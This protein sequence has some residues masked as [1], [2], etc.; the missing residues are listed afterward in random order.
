M[1][2]E[3]KYF[4]YLMIGNVYLKRD[5]EYNWGKVVLWRDMYIGII[6]SQA[7]LLELMW[8]FNQGKFRCI[9]IIN[10]NH[11]KVS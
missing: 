1:T 2:I 11:Q 8:T 3:Y 10:S 9:E 5:I 4:K 6:D 7:Y